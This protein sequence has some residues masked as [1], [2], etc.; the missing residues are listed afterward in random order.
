MASQ[1]TMGR[2]RKLEL[3]MYVALEGIS[4]TLQVTYFSKAQLLSTHTMAI[5]GI[6]GVLIFNEK[7]NTFA[8]ETS[9][10]YRLLMQYSQ[11]PNIWNYA[12]SGQLPFVLDKHKGPA[13]PLWT[14]VT[15]EVILQKLKI[16]A[17]TQNPMGLKLKSLDFVVT[18]AEEI[19][20]M[21]DATAKCFYEKFAMKVPESLK[22][23]VVTNQVAPAHSASQSP[24]SSPARCGSSP[25]SSASH[26]GGNSM[27]QAQIGE[28][29]AI[30]RGIKRSMEARNMWVEE[31][32]HQNDCA[33]Q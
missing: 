23:V 20:T 28:G 30:L 16:V 3:D 5:G 15:I 6:E 22:D 25:G 19:L 18:P 4:K 2:K 29:M 13:I 31:M 17:E 8:P 26:S 9:T 10:F 7:Q 33:Q 14:D 12:V 21:R 24:A 11:V 27:M 1:E 32:G